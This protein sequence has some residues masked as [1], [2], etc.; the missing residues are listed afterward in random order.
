[1]RE[2]RYEIPVSRSPRKTRSAMA[3]VDEKEV[4]TERDVDLP[5]PDILPV[6][7]LE[8]RRR[9]PVHHPAALGLA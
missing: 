7:P 5:I 9:L 3:E 6:L 2:K 4:A 1:M 8:G